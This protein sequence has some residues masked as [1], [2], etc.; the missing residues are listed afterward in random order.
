MMNEHKIQDFLPKLGEQSNSALIEMMDFLQNDF[1][2]TKQRIVDLT[3]HLD[4]IET[5]YDKINKEYSKRN[6]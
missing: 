1:D 3:Y 2:V 4:T 5:I 6:P